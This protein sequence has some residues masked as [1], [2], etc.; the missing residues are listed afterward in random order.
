MWGVLY[1][2]LNERIS[3]WKLNG[4]TNMLGGK[5]ITYFR[6]KNALLY[7]IQIHPALPALAQRPQHTAT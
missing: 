3:E 6:E 2:C 5:R 1:E 7:A 4:H